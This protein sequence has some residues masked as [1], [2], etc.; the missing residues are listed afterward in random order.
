MVPELTSM[1]CL[2][3]HHTSQPLAHTLPLLHKSWPSWPSCSLKGM[4][5]SS[6]L[7]PKLVPSLL[8]INFFLQKETDRKHTEPSLSTPVLPQVTITFFWFSLWLIRVDT[9]YKSTIS[10]PHANSTESCE[11]KWFGNSFEG[12]TRSSDLAVKSDGKCH[13]KWTVIFCCGNITL[14]GSDSALGEGIVT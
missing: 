13:L 9:Y 11:N 8:I 6:K 4:S 1:S 14:V 3:S 12:H 10:H 5:L 2:G 7:F